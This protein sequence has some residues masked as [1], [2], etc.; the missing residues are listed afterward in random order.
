M[1]ILSLYSGRKK[2]SEAK[3][4]NKDGTLLGTVKLYLHD[5]RVFRAG[6]DFPKDYNIKL[7]TIDNNEQ[8]QT[9]PE[10]TKKE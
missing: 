10:P 9:T 3:I 5:N 7:R 1:L 2:S 6:L 8:I 4:Y